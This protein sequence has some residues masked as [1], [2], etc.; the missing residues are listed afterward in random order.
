[1]FCYSASTIPGNASASASPVVTPSTSKV[2]AP[3]S[4]FD[5][6]LSD[7]AGLKL[8]K[9]VHRA[10]YTGGLLSPATPATPA[11]SSLTPSSSTNVLKAKK[12]K[13]DIY[14]YIYILQINIFLTQVYNIDDKSASIFDHDFFSRLN[15]TSEQKS[16][17]ENDPYAALRGIPAPVVATTPEAIKEDEKNTS[18]SSEEED[19]DWQGTL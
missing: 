8:E 3:A 19:D 9:T 6:I 16:N 15:K 10:T 14:I 12:G 4:P 2:K 18:S 7:L 11:I 1:M 5:S 13:F 17:P